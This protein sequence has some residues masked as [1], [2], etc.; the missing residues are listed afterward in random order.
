MIWE[1]YFENWGNS[2]SLS[3]SL[4]VSINLNLCVCVCVCV[5][6][7]LSV[8]LCVWIYIRLWLTLWAHAKSRFDIPISHWIRSSCWVPKIYPFLV[9]VLGTHEHASVTS[10]LPVCWGYK[11]CTSCFHSKKF[12]PWPSLYIDHLFTLN[13]IFWDCSSPKLHIPN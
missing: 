11:I 12:I 8:C 4:C 7:Y 10:F 13:C 6:V 9:Q 5:C 2:Y 3:L 1:E